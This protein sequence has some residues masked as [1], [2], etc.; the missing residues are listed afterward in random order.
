[1]NHLGDADNS[2]DQL[3][4][5]LHDLRK[6][7]AVFEKNKT[8]SNQSSIGE[9]SICQCSQNIDRL[10]TKLSCSDDLYRD[11]VY[12]ASDSFL[13]LDS[14]LKIIEI[15]PTA[16]ANMKILFDVESFNFLGKNLGDLVPD[17]IE[18]D[19]I[20]KFRSILKS[21]I[22]ASIE[23][24]FPQSKIGNQYVS[25][26]AFK[27]NKGLGLVIS[28]ISENKKSE[29]VSKIAHAEINQI[30][31]T[32]ADG[33]RMIDKN[34]TTIRYNE[35]F[36]MLLG[37]NKKDLDGKKCYD[38]FSGPFCHTNQCTLNRI[39]NGEE[40]INEDI[41]KIKSD[42][43]KISCI[44]RAKPY[45]GLRDEVIGVVESFTD[46]TDRKKAADN[47]RERELRYRALFEHSNDAVFI[48]S[49][50]EKSYLEVNQQAADML[51]YEIEEILNI[52]PKNMVVKEEKHDSRNKI[53]TMMN[54]KPV[55]IYERTFIRKD[56]STI[57]VE[58][59]IARVLDSYGNPVQIQS[60]A[61]DISQRKRIESE[62]QELAERQANFISITSHELRTP[63]T[64]IQGYTELL[65]QQL[66]L[67][68]DAKEKS[69]QAIRRNVKRLERLINSVSTLGQIERGI[70]HLNPQIVNFGELLINATQPYKIFLGD[71]I[72]LRDFSSL[73]SIQLKI[74]PDRILQTIDNL[75]E[76]AVKHSDRDQRKI[77]ITAAL[78]P[79][80]VQIS[81]EDN[82]AGILS[83]N[84]TRIFEPFVSFSTE[85]SIGGTGIG[86]YISKVLIENHGGTLF[87][88]SAGSGQGATFVMEL[89][90][91]TKKIPQPIIF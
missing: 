63:L 50:D 65:E 43:S 18:S 60:I 40:I 2:K 87:A 24:L 64:S 49:P 39:L 45:Y 12:Y 62:R 17:F 28:D 16:I 47:L 70:L 6:K 3:L 25:I 69:F 22:P 38:V 66:N 58:I 4:I 41:D 54:G 85:Y 55:S 9:K 59:N 68:D 80:V 57:Q 34:Y 5:E 46:I 13:I 73:S 7:L 84:L 23:A 83:K 74:D 51:G 53:Q 76:N 21:G 79:N 42:G 10:H 78:Y 67:D 72:E 86:L 52:S 14:N 31:N 75:I 15:N 35:T 89:P 71:Q 37:L 1:V 77:I 11:F 8:I 56:G 82:G 32:A 91:E 81:I 27:V 48:I 29:E 30:L 33:I 20:D 90:R 61:R 36:A 88:Q 26:K 44:L 19:G